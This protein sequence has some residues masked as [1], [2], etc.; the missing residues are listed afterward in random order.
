[1][2]KYEYR[3]DEDKIYTDVTGR[4]FYLKKGTVF[5]PKGVPGW[6]DIVE[7]SV[8]KKKYLSKL[9]KE[10]KKNDSSK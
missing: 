7:R 2:K 1:M 4:R 6:E 9:D 10:I 5:E 3:G 8:E